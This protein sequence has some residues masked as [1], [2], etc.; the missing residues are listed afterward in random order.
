MTRTSEQLQTWPNIAVWVLT[1]RAD[2]LGK[3][4]WRGLVRRSRL[5]PFSHL[6]QIAHR[7]EDLFRCKRAGL[8]LIRRS[9]SVN[10]LVGNVDIS[11]NQIF[12]VLVTDIDRPLI[13]CCLGVGCLIYPLCCQNMYMYIKN[14]S[15]VDIECVTIWDASAFVALRL[16]KTN[17]SIRSQDVK[18][19][20]GKKRW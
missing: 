8:W 3:I 6:V 5:R 14:G 16:G 10:R 11:S 15:L 20:F 17:N 4:S 2:N 7:R 12:K 13:Y 18:D 1:N 9:R 19:Y